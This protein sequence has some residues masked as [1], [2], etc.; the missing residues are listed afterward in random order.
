MPT[1]RGSFEIDVEIEPPYF[2]QDG[3]ILNRNTVK[4]K[5]SGEMFG[6]SLAQETA[7]CT[8]TPGS[9]GYVSIEHF[10]G[11]VHGRKGSLTF[12]HSGIKDRGDGTLSVVV[13]PDSGTGELEGIS[14]TMQLN[15]DQV[16][17]SYVFEY[18]RA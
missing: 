7:V 10:S 14:G 2:E 18:E 13:V 12:Q 5:F 8:A 16:G 6:D 1:A 4:K 17:R 3:I 11:A 9:V 15:N